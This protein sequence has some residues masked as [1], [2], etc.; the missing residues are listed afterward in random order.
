MGKPIYQSKT[1]LVNALLL[2]AAVLTAIL[3]HELIAANP[4]IAAW[5]TAGIGVV[6][7]VLRLVTWEPITF[8]K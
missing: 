8:G 6:N 4:R 2:L 3:D 7:V 5:V 1:I